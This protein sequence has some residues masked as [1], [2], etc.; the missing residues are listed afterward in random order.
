MIY[1]NAIL[2][3]K[4]AA[5]RARRDLIVHVEAPVHVNGLAGD[6]AAIWT[7]EHHNG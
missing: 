6:K 7:T 4:A 5:R 2:F 3:V 1:F